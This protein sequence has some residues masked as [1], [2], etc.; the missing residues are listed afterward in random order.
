[1]NWKTGSANTVTAQS[2]YLKVC[3]IRLKCA[4]SAYIILKANR[5]HFPL[6][7]SN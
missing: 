3:T 2:G 4:R 7:V 1:M 6:F 5:A